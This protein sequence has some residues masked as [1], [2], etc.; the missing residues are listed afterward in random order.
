MQ[1]LFGEP[2]AEIN[3][4]RKYVPESATTTTKTQN[5][6]S[7]MAKAELAESGPSVPS[8]ARSAPQKCKQN[9]CTNYADD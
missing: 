5:E 4:C 2:H 8:T 3:E 6:P 1:A 7:Y 9:V